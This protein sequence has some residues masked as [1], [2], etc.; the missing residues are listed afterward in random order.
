MVSGRILDRIV[1][2]ADLVADDHV[3]EIGPGSGVLTRRLVKRSGRVTAVEM[4]PEL[5]A[6]LPSRLGHP[7]GLTTVQADARSVDLNSLAGPETP[8]KVVANLPYYAA[9]PIVRR[10]LE[11]THKPSLMVIT[12]QQEVARAMAAEPGQMSLLSVAVQLFA[13]PAF[14]CAV[15][16]E[17]F[18]PPPKVTSAVIRLDVKPSLA[19]DLPDVDAFFTLVRAGFSSPRKQLRNSLSHG[20]GVEG[21]VV[22]RL[23]NAVPLDGARR[24]ATV[25]IEEWAILHR[26]WRSGSWN[27]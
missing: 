5:A 8:Y 22:D 27:T 16:P 2:A 4:D 1:A 18:R 7:S 21:R 17:A 26:A 25:T 14:V 15:P 19:V 6:A 13:E 10:F 24:P 9:N 12:V 3:V 23:L 11:S 20:L